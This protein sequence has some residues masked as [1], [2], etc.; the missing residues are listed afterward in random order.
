[1]GNNK[2]FMDSIIIKDKAAIDAMI[3]GGRRLASIMKDV[4]GVVVAGATTLAVDSYIESCMEKLNLEC[5]CKGY[6]GYGY[7]TCISVNDVIIHGAPSKDVILKNGDL[8]KVDVAARFNGYCV[9]M[10]RP[11]FVGD[12]DEISNVAKELVKTALLALN[13]AIDIIQPGLLLSEVSK[14]VQDIVEA[15]SFGVIRNFA[16]HGIGVELHEYPDVPNFV[17]GKKKSKVVLKEGMALAIEPMIVEKSF[18]VDVMSDGWGIKTR[19]GGLATHVED[20]IIVL[21]DGVDVVTRLD[22]GSL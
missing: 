6:G 2:G 7:A 8:V 9:D 16:G 12:Y 4:G 3:E 13:S 19:D 10:T 5:I 1:M 15:A 18:E 21:S 22:K 20:T 11:F 17:S 14:K